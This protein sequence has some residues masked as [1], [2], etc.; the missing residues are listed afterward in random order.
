MCCTNE[1]MLSLTVILLHS[2]TV[3]IK[4]EAPTPLIQEIG[5]SSSGVKVLDKLLWYVYNALLFTQQEIEESTENTFAV[6]KKKH[7]KHKE[8]ESELVCVMLVWCFFDCYP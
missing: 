5:E 3:Y 6:K 1:S 8:S 7:K 2:N 4:S